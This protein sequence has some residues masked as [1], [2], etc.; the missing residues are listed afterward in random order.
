MVRATVD[1][2]ALHEA[3]DQKRR[4]EGLTWRGVAKTVGT[5]PSTFTRL[6]QGHRPDLDTFVTLCSWLGVAAE[7]FTRKDVLED[8]EQQNTLG[9]ITAILH[10]SQDL[11]PESARALQDIFQAAYER[12]KDG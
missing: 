6:A 12:L 7:R 10:A 4:R 8:G 9:E 5:S 3:L 2:D 1:V 11:S